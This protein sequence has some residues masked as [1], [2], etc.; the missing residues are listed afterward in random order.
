MEKLNLLFNSPSNWTM[1]GERKSQERA[2][3]MFPMLVAR[4]SERKTMSFGEFAKHFNIAF[5]LPIKFAVVC[6][7]GTLYKLECK[8]TTKSPVE[9]RQDTAYRKHG[10]ESKTARLRVSLPCSCHFKN[11]QWILIRS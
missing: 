5:A 2:R 8:S 6:T 4:A 3:E 1:F 7:T 9:T 11:P 10:D